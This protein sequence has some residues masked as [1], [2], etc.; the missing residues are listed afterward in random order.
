V[1]ARGGPAGRPA[2]ALTPSPAHV[3]PLCPSHALTLSISL[4]PAQIPAHVPP[5][6]TN[7]I[8]EAFV[9]IRSRD[10]AASAKSGGRG[11]ITARQLQSILRMS[12]SLA[13]LHLRTDVATADVDEAIRLVQMSKAS[14]DEPADDAELGTRA[15][16]V[17]KI[18][19]LI[20]TRAREAG[21]GEWRQSRGGRFCG[22]EGRGWAVAERGVRLCA[23]VP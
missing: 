23:S 5:E 13:R 6:L 7:Y 21:Y 3:P 20:A 8:A 19:H 12:E 10:K 16:P 2:P 4:P 15:T 14:V 17:D 1:W 11:T 18:Y 22:G 9:D